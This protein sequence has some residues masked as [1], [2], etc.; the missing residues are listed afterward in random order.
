MEFFVM[1]MTLGLTAGLKPGPLGV[2]VIHQTLTRGKRQGAV[3]SLAPFFS[4]GPIILLAILLTVGLK[5]ISGFLSIVSIAGGCYLGYLGVKIIRSPSSINPSGEGAT[6]SSLLKAIQVNLLNPSPYIF[7]LTIGAGIMANGTRIEAGLFVFAALS[8]L[9]LTKFAVAMSVS[10]F[11]ARFNPRF[12][13]RILRS[14]SIPLIFLGF[15]MI[16]SGITSFL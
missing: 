3:A 11:G 4:D 12:Y 1:G 9:S 16:Y 7:W 8:T 13:A 15:K 10:F 14:L 6:G 2:F 5:E